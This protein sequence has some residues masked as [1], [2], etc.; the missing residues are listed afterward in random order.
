M[1]RSGPQPR[2]AHVY[3]GGACSRRR[4]VKFVVSATLTRDPSKIERLGLHCPRF[5]AMGAG[6]H[7]QAS[8]LTS[9]KSGTL[10]L[11]CLESFCARLVQSIC[12]CDC[13]N[14]SVQELRTSCKVA[15]SV[16]PLVRL[17]A[18]MQCNAMQCNAMRCRVNLQSCSL[19]RRR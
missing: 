10:P 11:I 17:C 15:F 4:V 18:A 6:D 5:V 7:R 12:A 1:L 9:C 2:H 16:L 8:V 19:V 14:I 13:H 3:S